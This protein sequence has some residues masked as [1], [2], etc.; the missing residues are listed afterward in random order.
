[1]TFSAVLGSGFALAFDAGCRRGAG[2]DAG[3][4]RS[5]P[6]PGPPAARRAARTPTRGRRPCRTSA[7]SGDAATAAA[8]AAGVGRRH[9][10]LR[11]PQPGPRDR[12]RRA[13]L[14]QHRDDRLAGAELR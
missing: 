1:M 10:R 2:A 9:Q 14:G 13:L 4:Q 11:R 3:L 6:R 8:I 7:C 12:R 5:G